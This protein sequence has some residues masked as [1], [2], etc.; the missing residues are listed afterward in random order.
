MKPFSWP[1]VVMTLFVLGCGGAGPSTPNTTPVTTP[2]TPA[3]PAPANNPP[4]TTPST[5]TAKADLLAEGEVFDGKT[6]KIT[7]P[8]G[9]VVKTDP[10]VALH[11]VASVENQFPSVKVASLLPPSG[12]TLAMV[13]AGSKKSYLNNGTIEEET[14]ISI[15][16][17][18]AH[19]L[20]L[21]QS[22]PG[23]V[24]RQVKYFIPAGNRILIYSGQS[25]PDHF[26]DDLPILDAIVQSL[27]VTS[28]P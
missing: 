22:V 9:W 25:S 20:V 19:R 7:L 8:K 2:S 21:T 6:F 11:A 1:V 28:S 4:A 3:T 17:A 23:H 26:T 15:N 10:I 13:V 12:T 24:S 16:G 27:E 14:E 5:E 18:T